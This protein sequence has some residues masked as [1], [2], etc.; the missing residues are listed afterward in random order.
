MRPSWGP[1]VMTMTKTVC[2]EYL[3]L[4]AAEL[5]GVA[6]GGGTGRDSTGISPSTPPS[7]P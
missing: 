4:I 6:D 7:D 2:I 5:G 1:A 3:S